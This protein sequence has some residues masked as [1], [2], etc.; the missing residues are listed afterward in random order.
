MIFNNLLLSKKLC[1]KTV[2]LQS[3]NPQGFPKLWETLGILTLRF[4]FF[5]HVFF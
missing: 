5:L 1:F 2:K 3:S 4:S